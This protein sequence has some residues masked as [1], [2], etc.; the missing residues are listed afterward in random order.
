MNGGGLVHKQVQRETRS[1][2]SLKEPL[3]SPAYFS[4]TGFDLLRT[5]KVIEDVI[6]ETVTRS[7]VDRMKH[8]MARLNDSRRGEE[9]YADDRTTRMVYEVLRKK[10]TALI[11]LPL[12]NSTGSH[13]FI[14][15]F[16]GSKASKLHDLIQSTSC[17]IYV[18]RDQQAPYIYIDGDNA[19]IL[20]Q[21]ILETKRQIERAKEAADQWNR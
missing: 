21:G 10:W 19:G 9:V 20:N 18:H 17:H 6:A 5:R 7:S 14:S 8:D 12:N 16:M 3:G 13:S 4:I 1:F 2:I 11:E 15:Y